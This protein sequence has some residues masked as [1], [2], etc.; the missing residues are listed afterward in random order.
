M[1]KII[2]AIAMGLTSLS[3]SAQGQKYPVA[4]H[5][6]TVDVYFGEK[7][8][9]PYRPLEDDNSKETE[10]WVKTENALTRSYLDKMPERAKY[11]NR[12]KQVSNYEKVYTPFYQHGKW[13]VYR[14][15]GLQ[16]QAVLYQ[17]DKL[18]G[19]EHVFLDPNKLSK[20]G[21]VALKSISFSHD[22]KYFAYVISRNGS[23]W[24][25]IY[26]KDVATGRLLDDHIVWAKFTAATWQGNGFYYSAYDAPE[27]GHET[28]AKNS[29]QKVYYHKLGTPQ[30]E[31]VIFYQNPAYPLRFYS[32]D[33]NE[34]ET[35]MFLYE[36]G[37][38]QG[39]NLYVR[40]LRV[41]DSQFIQ[42]T[43]DAS[44]EFSPL[45]TIGDSI[46]IRTNAGA[47]RYRLMLADIHKPGYQDW[48]EL[49]PESDAVLDDVTFTSGD[50]MILSYMKDNCSKALLYDIDGNRLSEISN[51]PVL[52]MPHSA[53][54]VNVR[55]VSSPMRHIPYQQL[56]I[57]LMF[58]L[59]R[60]RFTV[61]QRL[62][63][64][65]LTIQV[66]CSGIQAKMVLAY[67]YSLLIRKV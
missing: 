38:D 50:K 45:E 53:A 17:M 66:R 8:A 44:K 37:M 43:G 60:A 46:I 35:M 9:D 49:V 65:Q 18:G 58:Q 62:T 55:K 21:T 4:P 61:N 48:K 12:L 63:S 56:Y 7:V 3:A 15:N 11:L 31:D 29:I 26:V 5:D 41:P 16:N 47:E 24:E 14:N 22:G 28:S 57:V 40:D 27:E 52:A 59:A 6:A 23:D 34:E 39:V 42:M 64:I 19:E 2:L 32:V 1:K 10:T 36:S 51:S 13:Y 20:D 25:E 30:S 33:V 67:Q 54:S